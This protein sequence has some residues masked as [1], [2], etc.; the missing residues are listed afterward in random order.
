M[1]VIEPALRH[2]TLCTRREHSANMRA[3]AA[4][5]SAAVLLA[6]SAGS[7]MAATGHC[8]VQADCTFTTNVKG[9]WRMRQG[10]AGVG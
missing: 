5:A 8:D 2:H 7:A 9:T 3:T 10:Q 1:Q 6:A 4:A